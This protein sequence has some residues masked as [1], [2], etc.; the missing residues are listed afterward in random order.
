MGNTGILRRF[1]DSTRH[2]FLLGSLDVM[3]LCVLMSIIGLLKDL[4]Q[5]LKNELVGAVAKCMEDV[6][7]FIAPLLSQSERVMTQMQA[8]Q[9]LQEEL[10]DELISLERE[11]ANIE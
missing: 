6:D 9:R 8:L 10:M 11:A 4:E 3:V 1:C 2:V 7:A 5:K